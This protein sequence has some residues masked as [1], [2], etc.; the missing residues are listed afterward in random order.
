MGKDACTRCFIQN[1]LQRDDASKLMVGLKHKT[2]AGFDG[3]IG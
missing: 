3:S 2:Q 1:F